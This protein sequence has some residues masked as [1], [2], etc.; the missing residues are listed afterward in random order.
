MN[1]R[2]LHYYEFGPFRLNVSERLLQRGS[3][4]VPLT[5][6]VFDTLLVLV[7]NNGHVVEKNALMQ[8]L[9]PDSF[10]EESSL[11]Q[12]ISLLRRALSEVGSD[13]NYIE[14]IPKRGYRFIAEVRERDELTNSDVAK[15]ATAEGAPDQPTPDQPL[16]AVPRAQLQPH[17]TA[18][19]YFA[20]I[21]GC[22]V[23]GVLVIVGF[24][25]RSKNT[26]ES[27]ALR[28]VAVLPFKTIGTH[29]ENDLLGLGM[30]DALIIKMS[31]L[32][33]LTVLPTS[34]V[35]RYTNRDKE[36]VAIGRD[37]GVESVLDGTVQR[38]G[39]WVR[40]TAQLIR[41]KDGKTVWSGKF[42]ERYSSIFKLQDSIS[43]QLS[44]SIRPQVAQKED[45]IKTTHPTDN[46]EAYQAY[47]TGLYFWNRRTRENLPKAIEYLEQAVSLDPN[48]AE[49]RAILADCY[50]LG[51]QD[52]YRLST[53][54]EAVN[55]A[56]QA[57]TKAL[58]LDDSLAE[59]HTVKAGIKLADRQ[60]EE[61]GNE[62]RRALEL[63]P[64]Y[65]VAHVRYAYFLYAELKL[66]EALFHM[67]RAQ[68]LDPVSPIANGALAGMLYNAHD[69]DG[70]IEYSKRA[71]ELEPGAFGARLNLGEA[72]VQK[73][74]FHEAHAEFDKVRDHN[75]TYV[76]WE[77]AYAYGLAGRREEA[78]RSIAEAE[79]HDPSGRRMHF[80]YAA[81]YAA[82][83]DK[84]KAF[85]EMDLINMGRFMM[86]SV[87]YDPGFDPLRS[88]P[89]YAE[90]L[91]RHRIQ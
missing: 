90:F 43:E 55:R 8:Q 46:T 62:F 5:P 36:A 48:F 20:V 72:Y 76:Y 64:N 4:L 3:E 28:S 18:N 50:Y 31:R 27:F 83:G 19:G 73:R 77:K 78:L 70:C 86:A 74:M 66:E 65:A 9:W 75:P 12:N 16:T 39:D 57:V 51:F 88:D 84:D 2:A 61:A 53:P 14:T 34:S 38:D 6:K 69:F 21:L 71:L 10:V 42:D 30:A 59:A 68:Q 41:L 80:N 7:E 54:E 87:K 22:I 49:A 44:A 25:L 17:T 15:R 89:R 91:K 32:D 79:K 1:Q 13:S 23:I 40:V 60:F 37:L 82:L 24:W 26:A 35:F 33:Q 85:A 63:N 67:R 29:N 58:E 11:T 52:E 81:V 47:L 45:R 56:S